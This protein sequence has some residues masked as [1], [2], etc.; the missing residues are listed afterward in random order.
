MTTYSRIAMTRREFCEMMLEVDRI[1]MGINHYRE[2]P[3]RLLV[4]YDG[5]IYYPVQYMIRGDGSG[6]PVQYGV[7]HDRQADS[8]TIGILDK[9]E[10]L[11][12][13]NHDDR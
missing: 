4:V 10:R 9:I 2:V 3:E 6:N 7:M 1:P 8:L 11:E 12:D 5:I 13:P